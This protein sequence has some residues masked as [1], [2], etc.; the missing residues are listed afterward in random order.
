[1]DYIQGLSVQ[2]EIF[3]LALGFGFILGILYDVFRTV[4]MI[5]S[6]SPMFT[7]SMDVMYFL[8]CAFLFFSFNLVVDSG[9]IRLYVILGEALGWLIYYFSL[10]EISLRISNATVSFARRALTA[11][12]KPF[13]RLFNLLNSKFKKIALFSRK[14]IR[15]FKKKA[16]YDLQKHKGMVYNLNGYIENII[17]DKDK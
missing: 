6:D 11:I 1:M 3:L 9:K 5:I 15:K 17:S 14:I 8:V 12:F 4:R 13:L 2:T 16:K 10:G 7:F